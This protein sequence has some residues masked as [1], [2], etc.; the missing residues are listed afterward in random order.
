MIALRAPLSAVLLCA[1]AATAFGQ[2]YSVDGQ[3]AISRNGR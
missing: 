2:S 3:V 1:G